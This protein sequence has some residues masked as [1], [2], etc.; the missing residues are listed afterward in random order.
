M[1]KKE[2]RILFGVFVFFLVMLLLSIY[3]RYDVERE[4]FEKGFYENIEGDGELGSFIGES[5]AVYIKGEDGK[6]DW[7]YL[8][9]ILIVI[10]GIIA[11]FIFLFLFLFDRFKIKK[12][13]NKIQRN[14]E[15]LGKA[16][17]FV[18]TLREK[19]YSEDKIKKIFLDKGWPEIV[20]E[21]KLLK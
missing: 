15:R 10:L 9:L 3:V 7:L 16:K 1:I 8:G 14:E 20:V 13:S 21:E 18:L 4:L 11:V 17:E 19:D 2:K 6:L 12:L 5:P